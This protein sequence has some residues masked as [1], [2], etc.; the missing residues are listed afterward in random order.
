MVFS[1]DCYPPGDTNWD[2]TL[3]ILDIVVTVDS[4]LG[5]AFNECSDINGHL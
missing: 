4:A 1:E 2:R 5:S 3:D